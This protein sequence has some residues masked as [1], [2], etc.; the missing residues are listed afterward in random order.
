VLSSLPM[1]S[2]SESVSAASEGSRVG[3]GLYDAIAPYA[4]LTVALLLLRG[5]PSM[6]AEIRCVIAWKVRICRSLP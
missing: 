3:S 4:L 5:L 6:H 2:P 1:W